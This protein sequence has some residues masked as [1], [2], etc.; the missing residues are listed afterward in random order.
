[1]LT[2]HGKSLPPP[3]RSIAAPPHPMA[4]D[5]TIDPPGKVPFQR[6]N[7]NPR[8]SRT[9][10]R[11]KGELTPWHPDFASQTDAARY[12]SWPNRNPAPSCPGSVRSDPLRVP[13]AMRLRNRRKSDDSLARGRLAWSTTNHDD[14]QEWAAAW[15]ATPIVIPRIGQPYGGNPL[16]LLQANGDSPPSQ[17]EH[18]NWNRWFELFEAHRLCFVWW[19]RLADGTVC[20][21]FRL[22]HREQGA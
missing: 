4:P 10:S 7:I 9:L 16:S 14:I 21:E 20:P 2:A 22:A 3:R 15:D 18:V 19:S 1:M 12:P 8:L 5:L 11:R 13:T 17:Y 6:P